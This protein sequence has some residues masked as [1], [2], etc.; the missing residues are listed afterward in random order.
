MWEME[1]LWNMMLLK[2]GKGEEVA[3]GLGAGEAPVQ[4][5][6]YAANH[7]HYRHY[8]WHMGPPCNY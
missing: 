8:P 4:G 1:G 7:N 6:K 2:G 3:N 5:S